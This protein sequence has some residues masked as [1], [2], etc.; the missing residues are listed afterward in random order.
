MKPAGAVLILLF[1]FCGCASSVHRIQTLDFSLELKNYFPSEDGRFFLALIDW[2]N[3]KKSPTVNELLILT[4]SGKIDFNRRF[5]SDYVA[6]IA[7]FKP[8]EE[9]T[10]SYLQSPDFTE[11]C[12]VRLQFVGRDGSDVLKL[13]SKKVGEDL[14]CHDAI[15]S[16]RGNYVFIFT[17]QDPGE[18]LVQTEIR[19]YT[20]S[21]NLVFV[22]RVLDHLR[23]PTQKKLE[24]KDPL[25]VNSIS[26][27][28]DGTLF[29]SLKGLSEVLRVDYKTG[30]IMDRISE[31]NWTFKNDPFNGFR[32]QHHVQSLA[33]NKIILFDNGVLTRNSDRPSRAVEYELDYNTKVAT[34]LWE[35]RA[36]F[37]NYKRDGGGSVQRLQN[38]NTLI[39]WGMCSNL[40]I[41]SSKS[42]PIFTEVNPHGEKVREL[43][44]PQNLMSYRVYYTK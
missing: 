2:D 31:K 14:D 9:G 4:S 30:K 40:A 26:F 27:A 16:P 39:G 20:K 43:S 5:L 42:Y 36:D 28:E 33:A 17:H 13:L 34:L 1:F 11:G 7:D 18:P 23:L 25:H 32:S 35:Y 19:E 6:Y 41:G 44:S 10:Y 12:N 22:W 24:N 37:T 21:G 3:V 8:L 29:V 38:G 15:V